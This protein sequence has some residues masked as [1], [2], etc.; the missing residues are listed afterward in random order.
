MQIPVDPNPMPRLDEAAVRSGKMTNLPSDHMFLSEYAHG[1]WRKARIQGYRPIPV[2]PF[3]LG[4]QYA[5]SVF[6]GMKAYRYE[7]DTIAV[8][9]LDRHAERFNRSLK[10]MWMPEVPVELFRESILAVVDVDRGWVPAGPDSTL[11]IR[12]YVFATEERVGLKPSDEFLY[13]VLTGPF[14][15]NFPKPLRVKI[16][17]EY[18][19]AAPG[20][21][22]A[23]K[24]AGNY[25]AAMYASQVA[26]EEGFD[27]L[28]W[29]DAFTHSKVEEAGAMNM[30]FVVE[31]ALVT[32][33]LSDT[34]L[35]GVTRDSILTLA[36]DAGITVEERPIEV[37]ELKEGIT[38]GRITEA[39][40]CGTAAIVA[41]IGAIG[42]D[43]KDYTLNV[44]E[45]CVMFDLKQQLN[46]IRFGRTE[47]RY[48]WMT[49]VEPRQ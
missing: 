17:R 29:T 16:E 11:Y 21:V 13:M 42:I 10:R 49:V 33:P 48:D 41:P 22:G 4:M 8:F 30:M 5:Q 40:G 37:E 7:D 14:R 28:V 12:P 36:R 34:I 39:F 3:A 6:E 26:K 32:P 46:D 44:T 19:R 23:A 25:A 45:E 2:A 27:Q 38:S 9:R 18:V 1:E 47:D 15:P 20:G 31:G 35:D 24:C 43:G